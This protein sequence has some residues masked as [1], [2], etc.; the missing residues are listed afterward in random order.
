[1]RF[2]N[3][4][5]KAG[6][7]AM[8]LWKKMEDAGPRP[9]GK[10]MNPRTGNF[11]IE[12]SPV[13][14]RLKRC[15]DFFGPYVDSRQD[16]SVRNIPDLPEDVVRHIGTFIKDDRTRRAFHRSSKSLSTV[17]VPS[18]GLVN[19]RY[20]K[21]FLKES[22]HS[23]VTLA[24]VLHPKK[25]SNLKT[26]QFRVDSSRTV[27]MFVRSYTYYGYHFWRFVK[28]VDDMNLRELDKVSSKWISDCL[29]H[30]DHLEIQFLQFNHNRM[31]E[32]EEDVE[33]YRMTG[34]N[35]N[36]LDEWRKHLVRS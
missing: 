30:L 35:E 33:G 12:S 11:V 16:E 6:R 13:G 8:E 1:M 15:H 18:F 22:L 28:N 29:E 14:R 3:V 9:F 21:E 5:G 20:L 34:E 17:D 10:I 27:K 25:R 24:L 2:V 36:I 26:F 32:N 7:D 31:Y 23:L 19:S 4:D